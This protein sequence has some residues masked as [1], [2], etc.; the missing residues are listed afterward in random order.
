MN[1]TE[2]FDRY[3]SDKGTQGD[4]HL[5]SVHYERLVPRSTQKILEIGLG[6]YI[7][8]NGSFGS[9]L[10]WL[11]WLEDGTLYGFDIVSPPQEILDRKNFVFFQGDQGSRGDLERLA[12]AIGQ[13]DVIIDDG[14]H[15]SEHQI[16]SLE[17]LWKCVKPGGV[18]VVE[19]VHFRRGSQPSAIDVLSE[20][21]RLECWIGPNGEARGAVLRKPCRT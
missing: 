16:L 6:S 5:Y 12:T 20:D 14:S 19:D 10:A 9:V 2:L 13:V 1:L 8:F 17:V 18:Y 3:G 4:G 15:L 11:E 21:P 7:D